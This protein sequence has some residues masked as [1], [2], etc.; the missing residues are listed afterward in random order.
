MRKFFT[1]MAIIKFFT[2]LIFFVIFSLPLVA[3]GIRIGLVLPE[4]SNAAIND[5]AIGAK[6]RANEI[7]NIELEVPIIE[8]N[9]KVFKKDLIFLSLLITYIFTFFILRKFKI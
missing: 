5:I 3:S 4:L 9:K 7:G 2:T 6:K 8:E 1:R